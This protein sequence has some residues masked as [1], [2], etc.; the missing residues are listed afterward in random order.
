ML[1]GDQLEDGAMIKCDIHTLQFQLTRSIH[2]NVG[3]RSSRLHADAA[4]S[5]R[6]V[7]GRMLEESDSAHP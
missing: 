1:H 3:V 4:W 7:N 5:S 2:G 6:R